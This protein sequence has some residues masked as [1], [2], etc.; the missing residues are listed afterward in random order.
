M[1]VTNSQPELRGLYVVTDAVLGGGHLPMA[2]AALRGGAKILQLRDKTAS[3]G[4]ILTIAR[5]LRALTRQNHALLIIND[6]IELALKCEADGVHLGEDDRPVSQAR[7]LLGPRK[8][9][10]V[11]ASTPDLARAAQRDGASYLGVGAVFGTSTKLDAGA[12]IGT[13]RLRA[14]VD[15]TTLPV[16]AIGGVNAGNIAA[17]FEAGAQ[18]ACVISA[19]CSAGE[20][21]TAMQQVARDLV[22]RCQAGLA[23]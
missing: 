23:R 14:V 2:R 21:E 18:M 4:D 19:L 8:I 15:A 1:V 7:S 20:E 17:V 10:G 11:S 3:P 16:A 13:Q 9:I 6:S 5:Q 22:A 12:A